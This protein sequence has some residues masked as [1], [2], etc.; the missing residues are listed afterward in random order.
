MDELDDYGIVDAHHH[1]WEARSPLRPN[2]L[3]VMLK[4]QLPSFG[5]MEHNCKDYL[6]EDILRDYKEAGV[7]LENTVYLVGFV[8]FVRAL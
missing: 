8:S 6:L 3:P 2:F 1:L 5:S 7:K 4:E